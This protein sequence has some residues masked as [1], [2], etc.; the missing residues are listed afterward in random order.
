MTHYSYIGRFAPSP[1]GTLHLGS[2]YTAVASYLD[3]KHHQGL[4]L[5]R[6]EDID[7]TRA[8]KHAASDIIQTLAAHG[9]HSDGDILHQSLRKQRYQQA[10]EG[11]FNKNVLFYCQCSR[12]QLAHFSH[13]SG[14]CRE[15]ALSS[16]GNAIRLLIDHEKLPD[17]IDGIQGRIPGSTSQT[18]NVF[19]FIIKRRDQFF[20]YLF[21][22]VVDDIDQHITHV[23]RGADIVDSTPKQLLLFDHLNAAP[24][25]F[26]H[27]PLLVNN[28][29]QKL[30]K[31]N[32][33][34]AVS[35]TAAKENIFNVLR[36][37]NQPLPPNNLSIEDTLGFA[38][39]HWDIRNIPKC[40]QLPI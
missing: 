4:W 16:E 12:K 20:S 37:L 40:T 30:S 22:C 27:L 13:Y 29:G 15:L 9:M 38:A 14:R 33:S 5:I 34:P 3:A 17:F 11:L 32:L 26:F 31:Q 25:D 23:I 18:G 8:I 24:P 6:I 1:T 28:Q 35:K 7:E 19:D 2:L 36:L 10:L 21:S 39:T